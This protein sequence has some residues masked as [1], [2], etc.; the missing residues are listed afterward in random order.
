MAQLQPPPVRDRPLL[1]EPQRRK[2]VRHRLAAHD[3]MQHHRHGDERR[4][5]Q[6]H[7][8]EDRNAHDFSVKHGA[9]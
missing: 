6:Q 8:C 1:E 9:G 3:E 7:R 2:V 4:A 5:A